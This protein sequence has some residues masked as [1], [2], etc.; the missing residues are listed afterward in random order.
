MGLI[1]INLKEGLPRTDAALL[2]LSQALR[3]ASAN[4]RPA[5]KL[6]H[7]YGSS[8]TGG[9]IRDAVRRELSARLRAGQITAF[10]PGEEFHPGSAKTQSLLPR[11]PSLRQDSDFGR[12]ND[13]ITIVL[14]R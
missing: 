11:Y 5:I 1:T 4:R 7:G 9:A 3:M 6:I 13:G 2:R 8:G 10:L 12:Q 14:F